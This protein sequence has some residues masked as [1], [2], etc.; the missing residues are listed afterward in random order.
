MVAP[1]F[2]NGL[3]I[4][5][6]GEI[7]SRPYIMM[8]LEI[9]KKFGIIYA[10]TGQVI[11]IE[12]QSYSSG[13]YSIE[14]DWSGASYW[15]GLVS[16]ADNGSVC[17][18]GLRKDSYQGDQAIVGIMND[19]GIESQFDS[20]GVTLTKKTSKSSLEIDFR[21]CPDL[22]QTV[23]ATAAGK[24]V[25]L[26]M[27]GLESLKIK[28]T[29]RIAALQTELSRTGTRLIEDGSTW[30]LDSTDFNL[31]PGTLFETYDDHRMAMSFAPLSMIAPIR[32]ENPG[33][34]E[35][36]YPGYWDDLKSVGIKMTQ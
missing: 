12:P 35:K 22:A 29:D 34:V 11:S 3:T 26:K 20:E 23:M 19:L 28:E 24:R 16:L 4:E 33:V 25:H 1:V 21:N 27:T 9:M 13:E 17:L 7:Y 8:T 18:K 2:P 30:I 31:K 6:V 36:S 32:I 14:S 15:Y 10:W 5:L